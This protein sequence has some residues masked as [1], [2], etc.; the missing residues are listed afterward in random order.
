MENDFVKSK[1]ATRADLYEAKSIHLEKQ[2]DTLLQATKQILRAVESNNNGA[3]QG[4]AIL[5]PFY[6]D[7]L[8][9]I[10]NEIEGE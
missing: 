10:I 5:C 7:M 6:R 4:E 2:R 1:F 9:N 8:K 3:Y